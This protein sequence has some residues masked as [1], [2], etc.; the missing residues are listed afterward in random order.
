MAA[1]VYIPHQQFTNSLFSPSLTT[2]VASYLFSS[3]HSNRYEAISHCGFDLCFPDDYWC[4]ASFHVHVGYLYVFFEK[5]SPYLLENTKLPKV[6]LQ[7][8]LVDI[9]QAT[10]NT[11][12]DLITNSHSRKPFLRERIKKKDLWK[13]EVIYKSCSGCERSFKKEFQMNAALWQSKKVTVSEH[14][15]NETWV[16]VV[17]HGSRCMH[18]VLYLNFLNFR[19][20]IFMMSIW[21]L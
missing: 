11:L 1:A 5:M 14:G 9:Y 10:V 3:S 20:L 17:A 19:I 13:R 18:L 15:R 21:S 16:L 7:W 12:L 8:H 2:L 6:R 4:W